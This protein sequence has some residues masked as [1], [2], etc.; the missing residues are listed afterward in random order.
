MTLDAFLDVLDRNPVAAFHLM[1]PDG[2]LVPAHFHVTE[3]G[4]VQKD[5]IDCGGTVRSATACVLQVWV[6][7]IVYSQLTKPAGLA[8]R[9]DR[10]RIADLDVVPGHHHPVDEQ[11]DQLPL[12]L[13]RRRVE[14]LPHPFRE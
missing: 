10:E 8:G 7:E 6:A 14:T 12:P 5:F 11:L 2:D 13:E 4:R 1:L 9:T 3:V